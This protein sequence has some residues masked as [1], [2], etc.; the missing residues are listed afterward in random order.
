[1]GIIKALQAA[2]DWHANRP[3]GRVVAH[4]GTSAMPTGFCAGCGKRGKKKL[5]GMSYCGAIPCSK[6]IAAK[7]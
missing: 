2:N 5:N 7:S 6:K 4:T 1:M 3:A